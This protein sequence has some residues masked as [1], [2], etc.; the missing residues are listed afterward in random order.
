M[1]VYEESIDFSISVLLE[2][3]CRIH[4]IAMKIV[5]KTGQSERE[6]ERER[7]RV[8]LTQWYRDRRLKKALYNLLTAQ[9]IYRGLINYFWIFFICKSSP[10]GNIF[11]GSWLHGRQLMSVNII[12]FNF[13]HRV[14][15]A[16]AK[17]LGHHVCNHIHMHS[18]YSGFFQVVGDRIKPFFSFMHSISLNFVNKFKNMFMKRPAKD[19]HKAF[20]SSG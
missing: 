13:T 9:D 10:E 6:N 14:C 11:D 12:S 20:A 15:T 3:D 1:Y 18:V 8:K 2:K 4:W 17:N 7:E 16:C 5:F 19:L